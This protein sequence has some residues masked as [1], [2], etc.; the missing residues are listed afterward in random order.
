MRRTIWPARY[1]H[2]RLGEQAP[3]ELVGANAPSTASTASSVQITPGLPPHSGS[4]HATKDLRDAIA[5]TAENPS[6]RV[7]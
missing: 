1:P 2:Y 5:S 6:A 4:R 7:G 3:S